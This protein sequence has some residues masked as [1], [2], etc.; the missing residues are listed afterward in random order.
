M[1]TRS[2]VIR[3]TVAL[4]V[5]MV[6]LS[7]LVLLVGFLGRVQVVDTERT[8]CVRGI[9][10]R[11]ALIEVTYAQAVDDLS[12]SHAPSIAKSV[13]MTRRYQSNLELHLAIRD[14][15]H[16]DPMHADLLPPALRRYAKF[17]CDAAYPAAQFLP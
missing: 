13:R 2:L 5:S 9:A 1:S 14:A 3:V 10:D 7:A 8:A 6:A 15:K 12:V 11:V 4:S 17:S 16:V